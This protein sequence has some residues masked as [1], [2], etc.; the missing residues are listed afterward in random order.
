MY[1][2][3]ELATMNLTQLKDVMKQKGLGQ[4]SGENKLD[5]IRRIEAHNNVVAQP[6]QEGRKPKEKVLI[7]ATEEQIRAE[8]EK[9]KNMTLQFLDNGN[10][11]HVSCRG[12]EDSGTCMQ[13]LSVIKNKFR[14]VAGGARMPRKVRTQG[15]YAF[16]F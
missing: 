10:T 13:P 8:A 12:A 5:I 14:I 15:G 6:K 9:Y 4:R 3:Q 7:G 16:A 1:T 11:W 2:T